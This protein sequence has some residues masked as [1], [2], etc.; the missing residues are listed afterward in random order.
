MSM[1]VD[2]TLIKNCMKG[3][4]S[5]YEKLYVQC[6]P[7]IFRTVFLLTHSYDVADDITQ[8]VLLTVFRSLRSLRKPESYSS[9]LYRITLNICKRKGRLRESPVEQV[10]AI[11]SENDVEDIVLLMS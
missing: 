11:P 7:Q 5:S 10:E 1:D 4:Q 9:W 2:V 8:E 6:R 3:D